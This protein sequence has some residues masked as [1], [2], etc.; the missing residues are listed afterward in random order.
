MRRHGQFHV[1]RC[2]EWTHLS[3]ARVKVG[4]ARAAVE[5][6]LAALGQERSCLAVDVDRGRAQQPGVIV[7]ARQ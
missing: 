4:V 3:N 7:V 6:D 1:G 2:V 5:D